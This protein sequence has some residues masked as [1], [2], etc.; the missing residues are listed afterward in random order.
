MVHQPDGLRG[1][2]RQ[3]PSA[4][5]SSGPRGSVPS[6]ARSWRALDWC[7]WSSARAAGDPRTPV[8]ASSCSSWTGRR[9]AS[10]PLWGSSCPWP[11]WYSMLGVLWRTVITL[12]AAHQIVIC[13][14]PSSSGIVT[15]ANDVAALIATPAS[16]TRSAHRAGYWEQMLGSRSSSQAVKRSCGQ[17]ARES[18]NGRC[19]NRVRFTSG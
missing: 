3:M 4:S 12:Q 18:S 7:C 8:C 17:Q 6:C 2:S 19:E 11:V 15:T 9:P 1:S 16:S 13:A 10:L 5:C 14:C